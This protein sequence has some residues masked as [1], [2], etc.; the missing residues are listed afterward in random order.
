MSKKIT[1]NEYTYV[2]HRYTVEVEVS[3]ED[4]TFLKE[5]IK[6]KDDNEV[7]EYI[8]DK[9]DLEYPNGSEPIYDVNEFDEYNDLDLNLYTQEK[10]TH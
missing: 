1:F 2:L 5:E 7:I 6:Y 3:E 10:D 9:Y 8:V 4:Y